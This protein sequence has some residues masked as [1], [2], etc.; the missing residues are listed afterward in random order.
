MTKENNLV[1]ENKHLKE[2]IE[3]N[4]TF[5]INFDKLML[6][7]QDRIWTEDVCALFKRLCE[8]LFTAYDIPVIVHTKANI[9]GDGKF[10]I[11]FIG[12]GEK[13]VD[14]STFSVIK[15]FLSK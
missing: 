1:I 15:W 8:S 4:G 10:E 9:S 3:T 5:K 14:R 7:F 13:K 2:L 6:V 12:G 11:E